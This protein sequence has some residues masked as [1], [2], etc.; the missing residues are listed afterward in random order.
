MKVIKY[1]EDDSI[2]FDNGLV[3]EGVGDIDCCA[4]NYL[5]FEQLP[6]GTELPTMTAGEFADAITLKEDGFLVKAS[7]GTPKWVQARSEQDGCYSAMTTFIV[8][9]KDKKIDLGQLSGVLGQLS[10]VEYE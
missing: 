5:D 8:K 10:G 4:N 3:V 9:D 2:E 1:N 7:D 6:L